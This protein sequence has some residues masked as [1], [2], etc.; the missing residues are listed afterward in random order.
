MEKPLILSVDDDENIRKLIERILTNN[1]Y[2]VLTASSGKDAF[3]IIEK[4]KPDLILLDI[5]M[6]EMEGYEVCSRLQENEETKNIPVIFVSTLSGEQDK[7][8][9]FASGGVDY[10]TKPI[11]KEALLEKVRLHLKTKERWEE[12]QKEFVPLS[13]TI[14]HFDFNK[15]MNHLFEQLNI[16]QDKRNKLSNI[17]SSQIYSF[18]NEIGVTNEQIA[19]LISE[20]S[21][22]PYAP[23]INPDDVQLGI[24]SVPFCKKNFVVPVKDEAG[25][26]AFVITNPFDQELMNLLSKAAGRDRTF[27]IIITEPEN[28][29][30]L[31]KDKTT[32]S[33]EI[34]V[35]PL[36]EDREDNRIIR[37]LSVKDVESEAEL[38]SVVYLAN[39]ILKKAVLARANDI[40]I[41]PKQMNTVVRFRVDG[42][43]RDV[44]SLRNE[45]AVRVIT[46]FKAIGGLDIAERRK[47]QDGSLSATINNKSFKLRLATTSTPHGESI[48]IRMLEQDAK[49]KTLKELGLND[50]QI[51]IMTEIINRTQGL[52]L[53]VGPTGSGKTTT[54][55]SFLS[56][57]DCQ[58]HSLMTVEDP[59]E[60]R[61][62]LA[63]QQEVNE[64]AGI[65]FESLLRSAVRQDPD[66]LFLGE[67]RDPYSAKMAV[68]FASTGHLTISTLHTNNSSSAIF[69]LE[70]LEVDRSSMADAIICIIAQRLIKKLCPYCKKI[71]PPSPEEREM[72]LRFTN[73]IPSEVAHPAGCVKCNYTGY[74]GREGVYEIMRFDPQ[75]SAMLRS[76]APVSEIRE[77]IR[78]RGDYLISNH[79]MEKIRNLVCS[80]K[81]VYEKVL[82][83]DMV[84]IERESEKKIEIQET[85]KL[86]V[87]EETPSSEKQILV[88]EDDKDTQVLITRSLENSGYKVTIAEDGTDALYYLGKRKFDL[89]LSD[90]NMPLLDGFKLLEVKKQKGIETPVIFLT[91]RT[92]EE[93]EAKGL[94]LGAEDYIKKPIQK[95]L[96]LLRIK[97]I[98]GR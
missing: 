12:M 32:L 68:N 8:K 69:R 88:V 77:F 15:F 98:L 4:R 21:E 95:D 71:V 40:H 90:V 63:N 84:Q 19:K 26:L 44:M 62:P 74:Y 93:D 61:I 30:L 83:D 35:N 17:Q 85:P 81:D 66:I 96:L 67:I 78:K 13:P 10:L 34:K 3:I 23:F 45:T 64:K 73:D 58:I 55:Y 18:T 59:I 57:I 52:I 46:R 39:N 82:V 9:A 70:R 14:P 65:T 2:E 60:Y 38:Q 76:N 91:S 36:E 53:V 22:L 27:K 80:P 56:L 5:N 37:E 24:L 47:P 79:G 72:L 29:E 42:D 51:K 1:G 31:F 41:E 50:E 20:F 54:I 6:P 16:S 87:Q 97:K 7:A 92:S 89:I 86:K 11:Q 48:I 33:E 75:I 94:E 49:P 43:L 25:N 28:I